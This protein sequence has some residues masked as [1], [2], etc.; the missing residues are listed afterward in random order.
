[1]YIYGTIHNKGPKTI[2]ILEVNAAVETQ[3]HQTLREKRM[4]VVPRQ[5]PSLGPGE[6]IPITLTIDGFSKDDDRANIRW[7]V[8][9][10]RARS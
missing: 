8:T 5:Q 7:K 1:M 9:A 6:T 4:L 3:F 2:D 10:V